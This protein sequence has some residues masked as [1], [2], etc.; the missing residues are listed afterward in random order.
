[1]VSGQSENK[2]DNDERGEEVER[3]KTKSRE[4]IKETILTQFSCS[5]AT[6]DYI[7]EG[8][9]NQYKSKRKCSKSFNL[10]DRWKIVNCF[11]HKVA[12]IQLSDIL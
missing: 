9:K 3:I 6:N 11:R 5:R 2:P 7:R 12:E 1:M 10:E 8:F 4:R